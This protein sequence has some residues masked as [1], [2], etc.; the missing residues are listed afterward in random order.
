MRGNRG[1]T[2]WV[3][4]L[5]RSIPAGAGEPVICLSL[6]GAMRVYPR[7]CG[8]TRMYFPLVPSPSGLSPRVRGNLGCLRIQ[9]FCYGSIPAGA[10]EPISSFFLILEMK[11]YP[12]GC[13]GTW[14]VEPIAEEPR[15]LSP[16]VRGNPAPL[17]LG[18]VYYRSIPAGAGEPASVHIRLK[19]PEVYPRGCG[20]TGHDALSRFSC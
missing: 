14:E 3:V 2:N 1:S 20:G 13:G 5:A 17:A 12:R 9:I 4:G 8:G 7:G 18:E 16:R 15:G 6:S 11:V 10:G 19:H